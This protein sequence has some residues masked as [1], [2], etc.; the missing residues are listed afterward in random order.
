MLRAVVLS[1]VLAVGVLG[2]GAS[3]SASS[4]SRI[5]A[6]IPERGPEGWGTTTIALEDN[7]DWPYR[8]QLLALTVDGVLVYQQGDAGG[9]HV[10]PAGILGV[11]ELEPGDHTIAVRAVTGYA[12][13]PLSSPADCQIELRTAQ[14]IRVGWKP[15]AVELDLYLGDASRDF[16]E[17]VVLDLRVRGADEVEHQAVPHRPHDP[18][19]PDSPDAILAGVEARIESARTARDV[20]AVLC[21]EDKHQQVRALM[22]MRGDRMARLETAGNDEQ[23]AHQR[24]VVGV[25]DAKLSQLWVETNQC[26][27]SDVYVVEPL[28]ASVIEGDQSRCTASGPLLDE[29]DQLLGS[30][31]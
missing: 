16:P 24:L 5:P 23:A 8:L 7:L 10:D 2:C 1:W 18:R 20:V 29:D 11:V 15:A 17:R 12:A 27:S 26:V 3:P 21:Y 19:Q 28:H 6:P 30:W 13:T 22:T 9:L 31:R 14:G 4:S 25:I